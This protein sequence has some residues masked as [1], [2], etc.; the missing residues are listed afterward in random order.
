MP[1]RYAVVNLAAGEVSAKNPSFWRQVNTQIQLLRLKQT[2]KVSFIAV[3]KSCK[4]V[5]KVPRRSSKAKIKNNDILVFQLIYLKYQ[6]CECGV[7]GPLILQGL[8]L[9]APG[10]LRFCT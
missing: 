9:A 5:K 8:E 2:Q 4:M 7:A 1:M 6:S 3:E 10:E